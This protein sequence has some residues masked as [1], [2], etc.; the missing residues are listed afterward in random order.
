MQ[1]GASW[2]ETYLQTVL[3]SVKEVNDSLSAVSTADRRTSLLAQTV[4]QAQL[5]PRL[6]TTRYQA[7][8]DDLLTVLES[9]TSQLNAEDSLVQAK[10]A[11]G[12]CVDYAVQGAGRWVGGDRIARWWW[13]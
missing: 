2:S 10:L 9:Q 5:A 8:S 11:S 4:E 3:T 12:E 13:R 6:A 7:G 1:S